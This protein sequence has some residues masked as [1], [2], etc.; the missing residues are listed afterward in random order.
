[1]PCS[2]SPPADPTWTSKKPPRPGQEVSATLRVKA[3][4]TFAAEK[5]WV[6]DVD[7]KAWGDKKEAYWDDEECTKYQD[8]DGTWII[9]CGDEVWEYDDHDKDDWDDKK[10]GDWVSGI[11]LSLEKTGAERYD[12]EL[13]SVTFS[14]DEQTEIAV[15]DE[16]R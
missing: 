13:P 10:D 9:E 12:L 1:M 2:P 11:V 14:V 16:P 4:G 8:N 7:K 6:K 5:L 15:A 3:D